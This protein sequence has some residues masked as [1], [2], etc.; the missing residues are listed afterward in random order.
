MARAGNSKVVFVPMNLAGMGSSGIDNVTQQMASS[1]RDDPI[2]PGAQD[3]LQRY[4]GQNQQ[5]G[6][7]SN[8]AFTA[9]QITQ[10]ANI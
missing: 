4:G 7:S 6:S 8:P 3:A 1:H 2:S 5:A 10:L 9:G